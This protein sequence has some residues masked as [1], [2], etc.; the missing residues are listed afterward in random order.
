MKSAVMSSAQIY[1]LTKLSVSYK[2][3]LHIHENFSLH[4]FAGPYQTVG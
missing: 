2:M 3:F 1:N 4:A